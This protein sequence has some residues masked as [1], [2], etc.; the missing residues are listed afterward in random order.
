MAHRGFK[1]REE[2]MMRT[3]CIP[4]S[5]AK[6]MQKLPTDVRKT[7]NIANV[8]I[9]VDQAIGRRKVF[10]ILKNEL[11]H[12]ICLCLWC[13]MQPLSTIVHLCYIVHLWYIYSELHNN[14]SLR[15][16]QAF[17]CKLLFLAETSRFSYLA[18]SKKEVLLKPTSQVNLMLL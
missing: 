12:I 14:L 3:L 9:Y 6:S 7:S 17:I 2:L 10:H 8:R 13:F 11:A 15:S 18:T 16:M 1:I 4:P 5:K